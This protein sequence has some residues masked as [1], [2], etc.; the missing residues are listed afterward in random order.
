[1]GP[2]PFQRQT[3]LFSE[4]CLL[5]ALHQGDSSR[6]DAHRQRQALGLAPALLAPCSAPLWPPGSVTIL[7]CAHFLTGKTDVVPTIPPTSQDC[8][9][10]EKERRP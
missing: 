8:G 2:L 10:G 9:D 1:M 3:K 4:P 5:D 6:A 7:S